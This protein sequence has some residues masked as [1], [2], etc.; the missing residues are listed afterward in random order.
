MVSMIEKLESG[1]IPAPA[2][3]FHRARHG[4][5]QRLLVSYQVMTWTHGRWEPVLYGAFTG[6]QREEAVAR[7]EE[8]ANAYGQH[9]IVKQHTTGTIFDS[10]LGGELDDYWKE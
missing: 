1:Q 3:E 4:K 10:T 2:R 9:T 7:A 8:W 5:R 6:T